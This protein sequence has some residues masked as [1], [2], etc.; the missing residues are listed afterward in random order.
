MR[1]KHLDACRS[2]ARSA[3]KVAYETFAR[4]LAT[5]RKDPVA[6]L[7]RKARTHRF[8]RRVT[9]GVRDCALKPCHCWAK[10][11]LRRRGLLTLLGRRPPSAIPPDFSDLWF[12]YR[13]VRR[14]KPRC[15][16]EF[17]SGCS[18]LVLAQALFDNQLQS[19]SSAGFLYS[20]DADPYWA[21]VAA[22]SVP[23]HLKAV[24]EVQYSPLLEIEYEG[25]PAFRHVKVAPI[26]PDLIYLDGPALTP[27][28]QVA[29]DPLDM[30]D[31]FPP[32]F[33]LI[34]DGRWTNTVFLR[35]HLKRK[36]TFKHRRLF[37]NSTFELIG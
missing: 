31:R 34:V 8:T 18:T 35:A 21:E 30:E 24:C 28:R 22:N 16:L 19:S 12:L 5:F 6:S 33:L 26:T 13:V 29:V 1:R 7:I 9:R 11:R 17:G 10:Y 3:R 36:Y 14:R 20:V 15:I 23:P 32:R 37:Q 25:V 27:E 2:A 4:K